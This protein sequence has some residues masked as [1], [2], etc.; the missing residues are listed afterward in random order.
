MSFTIGQIKEHLIGM[1]HGGTLNKVR[2]IEA[3]FERTVSQFLLKAKVVESIRRSP[4]TNAVHDNVYDYALPS[5]FNILI[6]VYPQA[7]RTSWDFAYRR[8]NGDFDLNKAIADK[9]IAIDGKNGSKILRINWKTRAPQVLNTL[10][11]LTANGTWS[12][13]GGATN[14]A[15][16]TITKYSGGGS[17]RLDVNTSGDGIQNT[18]M[19]AVN[20]TSADGVADI[21]VPVYLGSDYSNLTSVSLVW[22]NNLTTAYFISVAQTTQADG[23]AF[24][25]G[26]NLIKFPWATATET[27]TVDPETIDSAKITFATSSTL[28]KVRVDNILVSIGT[29]FDI[30]YYSKYIIQ[31]SSTGSLKSRTTSDDDIVLIDNDTLPMFLFE[32]LTDMAHQMEGTDS[33]FDITFA[34]NKLARLYPIYKAINPSDAKKTAGRYG[35]SPSRGRW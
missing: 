15:V 1:G 10:D 17:I 9:T 11:S 14:V 2:N 20:L 19:N 12:A 22:G 5:D 21:F 18:T 23:S 24:Q 3:M 27:G 28:S 32:C 8:P 33:A 7:N 35:S 6:D 26:W 4:I 31:D 13:V 29:N 16:D 30:K 34:E 25:Y